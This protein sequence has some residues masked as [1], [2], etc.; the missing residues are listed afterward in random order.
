VEYAQVAIDNDDA[1]YRRLAPHC[2]KP[3]NAISSAAFKTRNQWDTQISVDL[4]RLTTPHQCLAMVANRPGFKL[5]R[6]VARVPRSLGFEVRHDPQPDNP[7]HCIIRGANDEHKS[8]AM[9]SQMT[10]VPDEEIR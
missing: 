10:I 1:L 2:I 3:G 7:A 5:G 6:F 4:A 8:R 9:A